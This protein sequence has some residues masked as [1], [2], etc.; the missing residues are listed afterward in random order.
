MNSK[1]IFTEF[2]VRLREKS[3]EFDDVVDCKLLIKR[4]VGNIGFTTK[5][6]STSKDVKPLN[7]RFSYTDYKLVESLYKETQSH[8]LQ[9][10][11][12]NRAVFTLFPDN[13]Y[14]IEY[15]WDQEL[16]NEVDWYNS[17]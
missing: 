5:Y 7:A 1:E 10:R 2:A 13:K 8:P 9:H 12:W 11:N 3:L 17:V 15:I 6:I 16:Q 4:L 14:Q